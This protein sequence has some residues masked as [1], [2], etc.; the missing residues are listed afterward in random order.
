MTKKNAWLGGLIIAAVVLI[1]YQPALTIGFIGDDWMLY[2]RAGTMSLGDYAQSYLNPL[3]QTYWYRPMQG[4]QYW[5]GYALF[6]GNAVGYHA[7]NLLA[8]LAN[9]GLIFALVA[10]ISQRAR[11]ALI[12]ALIFAT[13]TGYGW[14]ALWISDSAPFET[15]FALSALWFWWRYL[16][17]RRRQDAGLT[18]G[19]VALALL[20]RESAAPLPL[21]LFLLD[22][23]VARQPADWRTLTRRYAGLA[24]LLGAFFLIEWNIRQHASADYGIHAGYVLGAHTLDNLIRYL[25]HLAFPWDLPT[26]WNYVWL[27]LVAGALGIWIV[28]RRDQTLAFVVLAGL[29][30]FCVFV[31]FGLFNVRYL[32]AALIAFAVLLAGGIDHVLRWRRGL[33]V[34]AAFALTALVVGDAFAVSEKAS[35]L[36]DLSRYNRTLLRGVTQLRSNFPPDTYLYFIYPSASTVD[37]TGMFFWRLGAQLEVSGTDRFRLAALRAHQYTWVYFTDEQDTLREQAVARTINARPAPA[38]PADWGAIA[39]QEIELVNDRVRR[40]EALVLIAHWLARAPLDRDYTVFA[41]VVDAQGRIV[42]SVDRQPQNGAMPTSAWRVGRLLPDGIVIPLDEE[43]APGAYAIQVGMYYLPT[44]ER[45]AEP[46]TLAPVFV[47]E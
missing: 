16:H 7:I 4:L 32:Y 42:A 34:L 21:V 8:H 11:V 18:L 37:L 24:I 14:A 44:M 3:A 19:A 5:V 12:A 29:L 39:L 10:R 13:L 15:F 6:R 1:T 26:P 25:A 31:P 2:H 43:I 27:A 17:Q 35:G 20:T 41:H 30:G 36:A 47:S 28:V 45:L 23:L 22:R 46:V 33:V 40:G 9:C 38:L